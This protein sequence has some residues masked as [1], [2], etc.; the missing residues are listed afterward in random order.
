MSESNLILLLILIERKADTRALLRRGLRYQQI[1]ILLKSAI[2][3]GFV[4]QVKDGLKLTKKGIVK[5]K[6]TLPNGVYI[7]AEEESRIESQ[8]YDEIYLPKRKNSFFVKL[9]AD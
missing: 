3:D 9:E 5:M 1:S 6:Q 4:K 7:S 2:E 8:T